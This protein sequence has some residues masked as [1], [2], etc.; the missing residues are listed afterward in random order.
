MAMTQ[1]IRS[2]LSMLVLAALAAGAGLYAYYGVH[3]K[4]EKEK[5]EKSPIPTRRWNRKHR[6]DI[7]TADKQD[8]PPA[9]CCSHRDQQEDQHG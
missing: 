5:T 7:G 1:K 9:P 2:L 8:A 3:V 6:G 4:Q